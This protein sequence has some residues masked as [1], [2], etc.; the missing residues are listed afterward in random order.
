VA[1]YYHIRLQPSEIENLP[2]YEFEITMKELSEL[3]KQK[4]EA[5]RKAYGQQQDQSSS[6]DVG[7][8]MGM[9]RNMTSGMK[10]PKFSRPKF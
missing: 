8:Y 7:K 1:L 6:G 3:L 5:E 10:M 9:A 4:N 2:F